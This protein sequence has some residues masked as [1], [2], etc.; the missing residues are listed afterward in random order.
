M[1][2][3]HADILEAV[4]NGRI[5]ITP[6]DSKL[7]GACSVDF[8]LGEE[9]RVFKHEDEVKLTGGLDYLLQTKAKRCPRGYLLKPG[10]LVLGVT[11]ERLTLATD[12]TGSIQGRSRIARMGVMVHVSSSLIQPGVDNKQVLEIVNLSPN[13]VLLTPGVAICQ[14]VFSELKSKSAYKG[15]FA[16]QTAP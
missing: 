6:F 15:A 3:A 14:V 7:V 5:R 13:P 4:A 12:L 1:I 11:H 8:T 16:K 9:F 10:E 2:L